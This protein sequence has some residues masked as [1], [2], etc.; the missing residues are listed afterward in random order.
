MRDRKRWYGPAYLLE[1]FIF[2]VGIQNRS[3]V[4]PT[5]AV[6]GAVVTSMADIGSRKLDVINAKKEAIEEMAKC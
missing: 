2:A 5:A 1:G 4:L 6:V 3:F